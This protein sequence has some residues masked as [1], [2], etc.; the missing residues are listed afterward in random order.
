M[1]NLILIGTGGMAR[2]VRWVI[3][4]INKLDNKWNILGW[5]SNESQGEIIAGLPV[6][7]DDNW[8]LDYKDTV[9]VVI[10]VGNGDG[11]AITFSIIKIFSQKNSSFSR[12]FTICKT[13]GR[14]YHHEQKSSD[15][16]HRSGKFLPLQLWLYNW[17]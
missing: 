12:S 4:E 8:L 6:L 1:E 10:G 13:W 5:V 9:N 3:E 16:R 15:S 2:E 17:T 14:L 7:G 11:I